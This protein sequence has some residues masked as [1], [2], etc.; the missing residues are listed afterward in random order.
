M[1]I[2][3]TFVVKFLLVFSRLSAFT[4]SVPIF[5][6]RG[7]TNTAKASF[8]IILTYILMPLIGFDSVIT[9]DLTS[10]FFLVIMELITGLTLGFI[11]SLGFHVIRMAGQLFDFF[12]GFSM[13]QMFDPSLGDNST[14]FG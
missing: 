8:T 7:T 4:F 1:L 6:P 11:T 12:I 9:F 14:I 2:S 13:S 3:L 10:L 5:F